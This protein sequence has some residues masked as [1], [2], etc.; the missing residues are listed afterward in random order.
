MPSQW[1]AAAVSHDRHYGEMGSASDDVRQI[2][3]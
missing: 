1:P 2:L 3:E